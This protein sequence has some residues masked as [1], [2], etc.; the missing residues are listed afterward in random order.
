M[1]YFDT[2][3]VYEQLRGT[4][5]DEKTIW[6]LSNIFRSTQ[7]QQLELLATKDDLRNG[8]TAMEL[9]LRTEFQREI[10]EAKAELKE[11]IAEL[12]DD[13]AE[14]KV[15]LKGDMAELK[16]ELKDDMAE[17]RVELKGDMA[18]LKSE[19]KNDIAELRVELKGD[20][21][22]LRS[23]LKGDMA[24]LKIELKNDIAGVNQGVVNM[25]AGMIK[26]AVTLF[27]AQTALIAAVLRFL[28]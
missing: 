7:R 20:M 15:E 5:L 18:E 1:E 14:L 22:E 16:S 25:R 17:L 23:E 3:S 21:A 9:T 2:L 27:L 10:S 12:K 24:E 4:T 6:A 26:Y 19:L 8:L 28:R 11:D 13:M